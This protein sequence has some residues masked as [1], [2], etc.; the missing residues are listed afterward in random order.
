MQ[1][2]INYVIDKGCPVQ[3]Y[4][5]LKVPVED[6]VVVLPQIFPLNDE[7]ILTI[8]FGLSSIYGTFFMG[9]SIYPKME[10]YPSDATLKIGT[11]TR[12]NRLNI[13]NAMANARYKSYICD[14]FFISLMTFRSMVS[15]SL[16]NTSS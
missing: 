1:W 4:I 11:I 16:V 14:S 13:I 3:V 15:F 8:Y 10:R 5:E 9:F 12:I 2:R 6:T 7:T